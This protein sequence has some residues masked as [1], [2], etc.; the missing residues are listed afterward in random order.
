MAHPRMCPHCRAFI[1]PKSKVCEYCGEKVGKAYA[2][3][4]D[5][6]TA[7]GGFISQSHY[8]TFL[9]LLINFVLF[10]ATLIMTSKF[11]GESAGLFLSISGEVLYW[12]GAKERESI[13]LGGQWWRLVTAGFL[14]GGVFH[15]LMNTWVLFDLGARVEE[16]YGTSRYLVLY[17]VSS[18]FGFLVSMFWSP[19]LSIG[20]SAAACGLIG[21]MMAYG[22]RTGSSF[23][24][25][26]Y[27]R[28][29][30]LIAVIGLMPGFHID[31]AAH[32]G[33]FVAGFGL[34]YVAG[35]PRYGSPAESFWKSAAGLAV[36][37]VV[38]SF[39]FSY[40]LLSRA[41]FS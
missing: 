38:I 35:A 8:T 9:I 23:I 4:P 36:A 41:L 2:D 20:A 40:Q 6:S 32:V 19:Y 14:H 28:W 34:G 3:R 33:G 15:F 21:A 27:L 37:L 10:I 39:F 30:I 26:F 5:T 11:S 22:R 24:W 18:I 16:F 31:N 1:D 29:A 13:L 7:L 25:K 12:F 17:V